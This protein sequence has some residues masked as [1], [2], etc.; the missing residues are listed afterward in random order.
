MVATRR[1]GLRVSGSGDL[2]PERHRVC[3]LPENYHSKVLK[4]VN[5]KL[6]TSYGILIPWQLRVSANASKSLSGG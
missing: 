5:R 6:L 2:G 4:N 3:L 1:T